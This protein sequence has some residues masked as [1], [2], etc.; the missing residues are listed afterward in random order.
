MKKIFMGLLENAKNQG[1]EVLVTGDLDMP[2]HG[3]WHDKVTKNVGLKLGM[4]LWEMNHHEAVEEF[5]NLGFITIV[6]TVNL[7]L[8]MREEDLGRT[9]T[10]EYVKELVARGIDLA[11]RVESS[12][13]Q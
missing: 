6:V 7:S 9:L 11:E 3:C 1:A 4:P 10:H 12:I 2:A 5:I 13:R 8:G